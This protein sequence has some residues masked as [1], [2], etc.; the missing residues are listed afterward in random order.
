M[1]FTLYIKTIRKYIMKVLYTNYETLQE[2][3]YQAK[4]L[5]LVIAFISTSYILLLF[6]D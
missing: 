1:C 6:V 4:S 3:I 2:E 5:V